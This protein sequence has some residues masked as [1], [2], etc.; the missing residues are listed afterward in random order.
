[1]EQDVELTPIHASGYFRVTPGQEVLQVLVFKYLD[2]QG[3]YWGLLETGDSRKIA[4]E[5]RILHTNMQSALDEERVEFNGFTTRPRVRTV[6]LEAPTASSAEVTFIITFPARLRRGVNKYSNWYE[7]ETAEYP[8][9][10][11]WVMPD[12]SR[13]IGAK[14]GAP[15]TVVGGNILLLHIP[16][17][18]RVG[19][20]EE[21]VFRIP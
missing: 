19:G 8:Y 1:M 15:Y 13:I 3:Y 21:I 10:V 7:E 20:Y 18:T 2:P 16:R 14:L 12:G 5:K 9:N 6:W 17:G 4:E 11:V